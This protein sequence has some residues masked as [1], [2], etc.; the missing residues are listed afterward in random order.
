M[1]THKYLT[2]Y[3]IAY[4]CYIIVLFLVKL[5]LSFIVDSILNFQHDNSLVRVQEL[6]L[7]YANL[8]TD[9]TSHCDKDVVSGLLVNYE[10]FKAL[11]IAT[12]SSLII[13]L[14]TA[15]TID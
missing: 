7:I 8:D 14:N 15:V 9:R 3:V 10:K 13:H 5:A 4:H 1:L 12:E 6:I 2:D 11:N